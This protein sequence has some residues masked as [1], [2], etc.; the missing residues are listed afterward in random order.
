M[1]LFRYGYGK[2]I[3]QFVP[4]LFL[5][6]TVLYIF[7]TGIKNFILI[8]REKVD[9]GNFQVQKLN[10]FV[11]YVKDIERSVDFYK[12]VLHLQEDEVEDGMAFFSLGSGEDQV[13]LMLHIADEPTPVDYGVAIE[14]LVDDVEEAV[15]S[16]REAGGTIIQEPIDREWGVKEAIIADPDGHKIWLVTPLQ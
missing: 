11:V 7:K 16:I 3:R 12:N 6:G 2:R 9:M 10:L 14:F 1:P 15:T 4:A 13:T 5:D 8:G